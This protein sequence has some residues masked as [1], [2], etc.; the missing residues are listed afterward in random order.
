MK[1][2]PSTFPKYGDCK[3]KKKLDDLRRLVEM[4]LFKSQF[5]DARSAARL[6]ALGVDSY[7]TCV[8]SGKWKSH[9]KLG[10]LE[11]PK[12]RIGIVL[13]ALFDIICNVEYLHGR[14]IN[15]NWIYCNTTEYE[16]DSSHPYAYFSFLKQCPECCLNQGLGPRL[17][18][19]QHKPSSHHIGEITTTIMA[20][21]LRLISAETSNPMNIGLVSK[22][23]H[24]V[25]AVAF[26]DDLLVLLEFKAS[27]MVTFPVRAHLPQPMTTDG[28][29][30]PTEIEQH[31]LIPI[32][33]TQH[34]LSLYFPHVNLEIP[35]QSPQQTCR[36][37]AWPY[38]EIG[39]WLS[40]P[41]NFLKFIA[42]W[43]D[44]FTAYSIPKTKRDAH[45]TRL[46]YLANGW[47]D[48]IDSNKTKPGLG[49]TDDIKKGTYQ[50]IKY[51]AY[52]REECRS[53]QIRGALVSN[54]D[55]LFMFEDYMAKLI[56]I[57]WAR[58]G[59]FMADCK[60]PKLLRIAK[61]DLFYLYDAVIALN[62]PIV[63]DP[64]LQNCFDLEASD[65]RLMSGK[66]DSL[67]D[68]WGKC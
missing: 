64:F 22:Q 49:R 65:Q 24:D 50:L 9:A 21:L 32:F 16:R 37:N 6:L 19:A 43:Y 23:S 26:R 34:Q 5:I 41:D 63:N 17:N 57:R 31:R 14:M 2:Q 44:I 42:G 40:D 25:D 8:Q 12:Q 27:P 45:Q 53:P 62:R 54:L 51:G 28:E 11:D 61:Q 39:S 52:Y 68:E 55:P 3:A 15:D 29:N 30:G 47:G 1:N 66:L 36:Q 38:S 7:R 33:Y 35:I 18:G 10:I 67:L 58:S 46:A 20:L 59:Y 48:D 56:D 13:A 4:D 60:D